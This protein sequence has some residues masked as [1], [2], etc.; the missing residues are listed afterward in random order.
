M[1][2]SPQLSHIGMCASPDPVRNVHRRLWFGGVSL[3]RLRDRDGP[4]FVVYWFEHAAREGGV[5]LPLTGLSRVASCTARKASCAFFCILYVLK[6]CLA[7]RSPRNELCCTRYN[8]LA[9]PSIGSTGVYL[10][11]SGKQAGELR[12]GSTVAS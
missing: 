12:G 6:E 8:V 1:D 5:S 2:V 10:A 11:Q 7:C 9:F 4:V 3:E